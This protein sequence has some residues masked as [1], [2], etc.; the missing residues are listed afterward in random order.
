MGRGGAVAAA[1]CEN[2][3]LGE[4]GPGETVGRMRDCKSRRA[5]APEATGSH[6]RIADSDSEAGGRSGPGRGD[7]QVVWTRRRGR[8][9]R[10]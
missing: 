6:G 9:L 8:G 1:L 7:G 3:G 4:S 10:S 5:V 2:R